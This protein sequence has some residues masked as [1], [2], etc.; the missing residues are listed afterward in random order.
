L[1]RPREAARQL[2]RLPFTGSLI[3]L[4]GLV[5]EMLRNTKRD[6]RWFERVPVAGAAAVLELGYLGVVYELDNVS[7]GGARLG[8]TRKPPSTSFDILLRVADRYMERRARH[9][10]DDQNGHMG[11]EFEGLAVQGSL[12]WPD[13]FEM[14]RQAWAQ[15]EP[16]HLN[17][18]AIV[19]LD[20][21]MMSASMLSRHL[22]YL[23]QEARIASTPL[24]AIDMIEKATPRVHALFIAPELSGCSGTDLANFVASTY[25]GVSRVLLNP[26]KA[27]RVIESTAHDVLAR[28]WS[29]PSVK[30]ALD[31]IRKNLLPQPLWPESMGASLAVL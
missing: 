3:A 10:W 11:I 29:L 26:G 13:A 14:E 23:G 15:G 24:E 22:A 20:E 17:R 2:R 31:G 28:P 1:G 6:R 18:G 16:A 21:D 9:I 19:I 30:E 27:G 7:L 8:G 5:V 25:P 4:H 12:E